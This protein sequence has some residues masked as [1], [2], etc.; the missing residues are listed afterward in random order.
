M[1]VS[2]S[3]TGRRGENPQALEITLERELGKLAPYLWKKGC[4]RVREPTLRG[5]GERRGVAVT[6]LWRLFIINT[7]LCQAARRRIGCDACPVPE[8]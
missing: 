4:P 7:A 8:G 1:T 6:W 5:L 3:D 2:Q